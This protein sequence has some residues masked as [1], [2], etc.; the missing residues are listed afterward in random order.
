[1]LNLFCDPICSVDG[2]LSFL[3]LIVAPV[4][5]IPFLRFVLSRM[6]PMTFGQGALATA[7]C[8]AIALYDF[9]AAQML[10]SHWTMAYGRA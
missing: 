4:L 8:L 3:F 9:S 5:S 2:I 6:A 10:W 1:M 7:I